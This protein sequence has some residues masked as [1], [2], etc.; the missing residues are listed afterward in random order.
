MKQEDINALSNVIKL[1]KD[2]YENLL[3]SFKKNDLKRIY[4]NF[5]ALISA[6]T[7]NTQEILFKKIINQ[8]N[9][10]ISR[11]ISPEIYYIIG[12]HGGIIIDDIGFCEF[13]SPEYVLDILIKKL[14]IAIKNNIPLNLE[15]AVSCFEWLKNHY[16]KKFSELLNKVRDGKIEL[17]NPSYAQP[18][19]LIIGPESNIKHFEFGLRALKK[20]GLKCHIFYCSEASYHPQIPQILKGFGLKYGSLRTR[21]LGLNPASHSAVIKWVGLDGTEIPALIDQAGLY[22]GEYFHGTFFKQIPHLLT[23]AL[24]R[25]F[26]KEILFSNIEDLVMDMPFQEDIFRISSFSELF[27]HFSTSTEILNRINI[28]TCIKYRRDDFL[29]GN[30]LFILPEL[31]LQNKKSEIALITAESVNC[32]A[33]FYVKINNDSV[34]E[35]LWRELLL[36]QAHDCYAVPFIKSGDYYNAQ[37]NSEIVNKIKLTPTSF[38]LSELC[39]KK[40]A[41]IQEKSERIQKECLDLLI[42]ELSNSGNNEKNNNF[43]FILNPTSYPIKEYIEFDNKD[44]GFIIEVP[45][46]GFKAIKSLKSERLESQKISANSEFIYEIFLAKDNT[47]LIVNYQ[48]QQVYEISIKSQSNSDLKFNETLRKTSQFKQLII[49][50]SISN[51]SKV[52]L[53]I[54]QYKDI[55]RVEFCLKAEKIKE[56]ILKPA[57]KIHEIHINYPF[58]IEKT[59]RKEIQTLD[60][61]ILKDK[62]KSILL[63]HKNLHK[64]ILDREKNEYKARIFNKGK[65]KF[66]ISIINN[67]ESPFYYLNS[68]YY[69]LNPIKLEEN[70]IFPKMEMSFLK[71]NP[72]VPII[73]LFR[74]NNHSFLRLFNPTPKEIIIQITSA[75]N[76]KKFDVMNL[77]LIKI[78]EAEANN[79]RIK[80]WK[81]KTLRF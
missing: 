77:N 17:I 79:I 18:Y 61:L 43:F 31:L 76:I 46:F 34:L 75:Y 1:I 20:M 8:L 65:F 16:P 68:Y 62:D 54:I 42:S 22:N 44:N 78:K 7:D 73:N 4:K 56:I 37:L 80:P 13:D 50:E 55:N 36:I 51:G 10:I 25:P 26:L 15:I 58:G 12:L 48:N 14:E 24:T 6:K 38:S 32:L 69:N 71:T 72:L 49:F 11:N 63:M 2:F 59:N 64:F 39:F 52:S 57:L 41:L 33:N 23:Q 81:I 47:S 9:K 28:E 3:L 74:R 5:E 29:L 27:G 60:F 21:L 35:T 45:P 19:N 66:A 67:D 53:Y 30:S 70:L 40:H